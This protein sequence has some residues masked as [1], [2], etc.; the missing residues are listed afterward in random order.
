LRRYS[1]RRYT[2][3]GDLEATKEELPR[4]DHV[5]GKVHQKENSPPLPP[6]R[7]RTPTELHADG[8]FYYEWIYDVLRNNHHHDLKTTMLNTLKARIT[9]IHRSRLQRVMVD[10]VDPNRLEREKPALFHI[11]KTRK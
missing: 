2:S 5:V 9:T 3:N 1:E 7:S 10:N 6:E 11:L 8:K 4:L